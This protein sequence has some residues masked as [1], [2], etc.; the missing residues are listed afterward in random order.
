M[1]RIDFLKKY[2][3]QGNFLD[4]GNLYSDGARHKMLMKEYPSS[5]FYG[6]DVVDQ[7]TVGL[8]F[9]NQFVGSCTKLPFGDELFDTIYVGQVI[10][11]VWNPKDMVDEC[12]RTLKQGGVFIFD[13]PNV[14]SLSRMLRYSVTGKDVIIGNPEH[15][16]FF[17][18]AMLE[19]ILLQSGFKKV[20]MMTEN[21]FAFKGKVYWLPEA[22]P[23]TYLGECICVCAIK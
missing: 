4:V 7:S 6:L 8:T 21:N 3:K 22:K 20:F 11:H 14:Y 16:F 12:F 5:K 18:F 19:N 1:K 13:T 15:K 2:L 23:F 9:E 10:E 17:S